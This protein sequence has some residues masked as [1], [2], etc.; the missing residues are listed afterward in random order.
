MKTIIPKVAPKDNQKLASYNNESG[1][2]NSKMLAIRNKIAREFV[3]E[4]PRIERYEIIPIID[5]RITGISHP[6]SVEYP[7]TKPKIIPYFI[8]R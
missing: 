4:F 8:N 1:S 2:I 5:A 3:L 6:T 7:I